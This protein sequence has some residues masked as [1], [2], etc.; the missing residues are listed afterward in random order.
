MQG[1][2]RLKE[3]IERHRENKDINLKFKTPL[4]SEFSPYLPSLL[5]P[6]HRIPHTNHS[7]PPP[8]RNKDTF[9]DEQRIYDACNPLHF[10]RTVRISTWVR[11]IQGVS[12]ILL[13]TS[14]A[15]Y[16]KNVD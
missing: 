6:L 10:S 15:W 9:D 11:G 7:S 12:L 1:V 14:K 2:M 16:R 8:V 4:T 3:A 5:P 13:A